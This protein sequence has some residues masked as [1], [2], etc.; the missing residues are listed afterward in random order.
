MTLAQ[1]AGVQVLT[2]SWLFLVLYPDPTPKKRKEGLVFQ[3][4]FLIT[5]GGV[6]QRKE[7]NYCIPPCILDLMLDSYVITIITRSGI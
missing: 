2:I 5:W 7:C 4:T 1:L 3:T 6:E